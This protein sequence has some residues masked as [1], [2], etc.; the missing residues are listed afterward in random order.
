MV[1]HPGFAM[2]I[3]LLTWRSTARDTLQRMGLP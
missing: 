3:S 2:R 1:A